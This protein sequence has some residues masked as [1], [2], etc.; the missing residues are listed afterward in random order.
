MLAARSTGML[1]LSRAIP[2]AA[3]FDSKTKTVA[4]LAAVK[5]KGTIPK[6]PLAALIG[7]R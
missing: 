3:T 4:L 5:L 7:S 2:C 1:S 6:N